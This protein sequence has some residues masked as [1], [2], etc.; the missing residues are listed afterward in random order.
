MTSLD[1]AA[2][3]LRVVVPG[4]LALRVFYWRG[5]R[6]QRTD[7]ELVLWSL[8]LSVPLY[9]AA[10]LVRPEDDT[11]TLAAAA[12]WAVLAGE[13]GAQAWRLVVHLWPWWREYMVATAWDGVLAR[14]EGGWL[15]VRTADGTMYQGWAR[16]VADSGQTSDLDLYLWE[17]A[18]VND[19]Q[20]VAP[21]GGV[22]GVLIP[23]SSIRSVMRFTPDAPAAE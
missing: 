2:A 7:L 18:Y 4:F 13:I 20:T 21:I 12:L 15:Q 9:W 10:L 3:T 14:P 16:L 17:P 19:D 1:D 8:V 6:T 11:L 5:L 22:E 23:R